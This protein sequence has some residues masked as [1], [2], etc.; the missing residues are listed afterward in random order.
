MAIPST[1]KKLDLLRSEIGILFGLMTTTIIYTFG[2]A[3]LL[4]LSNPIKFTLLFIW[5]FTTMLWLS[6]RVVNHADCLAIILGE[7]FGTLILTLSV[8]SIEVVMITAVMLT[9]E[10]SITLA[11]DTMFSV[12]MIVLNGMLG[13][14][15][16]IG[17]LKHSE[18]N[19]NESGSRSYLSLLASLAVLGLVVPRFTTSAPGGQISPL[20]AVYLL[21]VCSG[22]YAI[23]LLVQT[24][25]HSSFFMQPLIIEKENNNIIQDHEDLK[26]YSISYHVFML[27]LSMLPIVLMSKGMAKLV[28]HGISELEAPHA[29]GG[30]LVAI[31]VLSPEGLSAIKAAIANQVQRTVNIAMGSALA[32]IGL[33]I[34]AI[35]AVSLFTG[36]RIELGLDY[37]DIVLLS[38]TLLVSAINF[39]CGKTNILQGAVHLLLFFSYTLLM[40]D[41]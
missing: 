32:T 16:V 21:L 9:G 38:L 10:G 17:G 37:L 2:Q 33:T 15:L 39:G 7:P 18:Q 14:T 11:R 27:C 23:F 41:S 22:L 29:L 34:P 35:L 13:L 36:K 28:D 20:L 31:L 5:F 25:R 4:D 19:F 12:F 24:K 30:F 26:I 6:F 8:I 1:I 40:F 3:W